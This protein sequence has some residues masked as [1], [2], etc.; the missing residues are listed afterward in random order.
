MQCLASRAR[1]AEAHSALLETAIVVGAGTV[2]RVSKLFSF[3][4]ATDGIGMQNFFRTLRLVF[5]Y[6]WTLAGSTFTAIMVAALW[7]INIGGA[8]PVLAIITSGESVQKWM[9]EDAD[10]SRKKIEALTASIGE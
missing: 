3:H 6:K 4:P 8:Y 10:Q 1:S 7:G 2:E 5:R 9:R